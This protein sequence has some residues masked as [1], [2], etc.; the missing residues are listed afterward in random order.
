MNGNVTREGITADLES[1]L[2]GLVR[3]TAVATPRGG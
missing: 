1:G 3:L 2:L